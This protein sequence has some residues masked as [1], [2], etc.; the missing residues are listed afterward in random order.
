MA[1]FTAV[2]E[3][4]EEK[5]LHVE[6]SESYLAVGAAN[7]MLQ[8]TLLLCC[9]TEVCNLHAV[10]ARP[11]LHDFRSKPC[12]IIEATLWSLPCCSRGA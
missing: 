9:A 7:C 12:M 2:R 10:M 5:E 4:I 3:N 6:A 11:H 8:T 1:G